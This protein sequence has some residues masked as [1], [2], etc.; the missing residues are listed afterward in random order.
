MQPPP[1]QGAPTSIAAFA[2]GAP[3]GPVNEPA[4]IGSIAEYENTFGAVNAGGTLGPAVRDFFSNGGQEA[5][6][7]RVDEALR[8]CDFLS[9]ISALDD[10]PSFN[11]LVIPPFTASIDVSEDVIAAAAAYCETRRAM[12]L[13]DAPRAWA[14]VES[15]V[16]GVPEIGT[17]SANAAVFFPRLAGEAAVSGAVAGVYARMDATRGIWR[18]PAGA[19]AVITGA[20]QLALMLSDSDSARLNR[21]GI[22]PIRAF[23]G[24]RV[25]VWGARTLQGSD[26]QQS[27]WKYV[28]VRRFALYL[29]SSIDRGLQWVQFEPNGPTLWAA[30]RTAV[31]GFLQSLFLQGAFQG[32][33][34]QE[35]YFVRCDET[36]MTQEDIDNG[37]VIVVV[38]AAVL[39]PAEFVIITIGQMAGCGRCPASAAG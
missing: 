11:L 39:R 17:Q 36:T 16:A 25:L 13:I 32:T 21:A 22:N 29:E 19:E 28:N 31:A 12:L 34:P 26:A 23:P 24:P 1:I 38:G 18:V 7:V 33:T 27:E 8:D 2:G 35:A 3:Q 10:V 37:R 6:V 5:Y 4:S 15:A 14:D 30:V 20:T 9:G